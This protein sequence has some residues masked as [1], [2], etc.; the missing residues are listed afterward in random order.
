MNESLLRNYEN[1]L[2]NTE[3][4]KEQLVDARASDDD[5]VVDGRSGS[6]LR[7]LDRL[8]TVWNN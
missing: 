5:T 3:T 7:N 4:N 6:S 1:M 2:K 8:I